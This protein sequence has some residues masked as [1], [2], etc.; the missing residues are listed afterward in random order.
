[1]EA[2]GL[3]AGFFVVYVSLSERTPENYARARAD[4]IT[5]FEAIHRMTDELYP[6]R[7]GLARAADDF[8]RIAESGRLVAAIGVE[9]GYV[10]G[11]DLSLVETYYAL[12]H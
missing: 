11:Q 7:I 8:A 5:K 10:I 3:D 9:N 2:G 1:M 12:G 4:A 6:E